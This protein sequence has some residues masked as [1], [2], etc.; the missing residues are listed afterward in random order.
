MMRPSLEGLL[1]GR[2]QRCHGPVQAAALPQQRGALW[3]EGKHHRDQHS[4]DSW[5]GLCRSKEPCG[6]AAATAGQHCLLLSPKAGALLQALSPPEGNYCSHL[7][8]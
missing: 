7:Q 5:S 3:V 1:P 8:C 6:K 2:Q 4:P